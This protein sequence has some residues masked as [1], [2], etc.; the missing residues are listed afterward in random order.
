[1]EKKN[2]MEKKGR[3]VDIIREK[4]VKFQVKLKGKF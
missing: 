3:K 1:M 4:V 2:W